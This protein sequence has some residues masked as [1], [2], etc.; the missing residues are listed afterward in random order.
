M[1][2]R[3]AWRWFRGRRAVLQIASWLTLAAVYTF[4]LV[5]LVGGDDGDTEGPSRESAKPRRPMSQLE[6]QVASIVTGVDVK[7]EEPTD[8]RGYRAPRQ[9][10]VRCAK[11][12]CDITYSVGLPGRGRIL[13]DQRQIWERLF[14]ETPVRRAT[15][16][17]VRDQAAAGVPPKPDEE[18]AS[19]AAIMVTVCDQ[20]KRPDVDWSR[21]DGVEILANICAVSYEAGGGARRQEPVA[22]DD[23]AAGDARVGGGGG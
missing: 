21:R 23:P 4:V 20:G 19:G 7:T 6:R 15:M 12:R 14:A 17:V 3:Q 8:V 10:S 16:N 1:G 11:N 13:E 22:P 9:P 2:F 18:V 5:A